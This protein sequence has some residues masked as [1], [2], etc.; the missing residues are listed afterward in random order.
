M[1]EIVS[2]TRQ[3]KQDFPTK[4]PLGLSL[5]RLST[6]GGL[7][8]RICCNNSLP[9]PTVYNASIESKDQPADIIVFVHDD[10]WIDDYFAIDRIREGLEKFDIVGL[11]G[12]RRR[13][14]NQPAWPWVDDKFSGDNPAN[15]SGAV[16]HGK[17]P[18]G[19]VAWYGVAP[20]ECELLDGLFLAARRSALVER[21]VRFDPQFAFHFYDLDFC[22]TARSRGLRLGTCPIAVTH[23]SGGNFRSPQWKEGLERY[24]EKWKD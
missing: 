23:Q 4:T 13:V 22:R 6:K 12:N 11:A 8:V 16:A 14:P 7:K 21:E 9:L 5:G 20:A 24:R 3:S 19:K 10:V 15:L 18:F 17:H 1:V 2:A